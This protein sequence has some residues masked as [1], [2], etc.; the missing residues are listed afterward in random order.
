MA[1][2]YAEPRAL[3]YDHYMK[4]K[5]WEKWAD[6]V[7]LE[8]VKKL[9]NF[10]VRWDYHF[11][12]DSQ[13]FVEIYEKVSPIIQS[14]K[15]ARLEDLDLDNDQVSDGI[16]QVF[17]SICDCSW[18]YE[19][20]DTSKILHTIVPDLFMMWDR[21]IRKRILGDVER[22]W[23]AVYAVDFL[24]KMQKEVNDCISSFM[25]EKQNGRA[26]ATD[27][28]RGLCDHKSLPKLIDE[29][30]YM[31]CTRPKDFLAFIEDLKTRGEI[32]PVDYERIAQKV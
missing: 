7:P 3:Y 4:T 18:K 19:S 2:C 15:N 29:F 11:Q 16:E 24:P 30:N 25:L 1:F 23:G 22:N 14:L 12:G 32:S 10:I 9:F 17:D 13:K 8:E 27:G 6:S 5:N 20:T 21:K 26:E 31:V 28:I